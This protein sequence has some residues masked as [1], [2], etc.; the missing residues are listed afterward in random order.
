MIQLGSEITSDVEVVC[1]LLSRF[2]FSEQNPPSDTQ[3]VEIFTTL[4]RFAAEGAS[5]CD[6]GALVRA[7]SNFVS[8]SPITVILIFGNLTKD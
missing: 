5:L 2:G 6:V 7:L 1:G 8:I 4:G 3:A